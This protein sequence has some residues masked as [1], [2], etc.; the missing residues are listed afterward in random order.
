MEEGF[1]LPPSV[2]KSS[3]RFA[4]G[5]L[6]DCCCWCLTGAIDGGCSVLNTDGFVPPSDGKSSLSIPPSCTEKLL[7]NFT[8]CAIVT[9]AAEGGGA[10]SFAAALSLAV[11]LVSADAAVAVIVDSL[12]VDDDV[13]AFGAYAKSSS[14]SESVSSLIPLISTPA[15]TGFSDDVFV[16]CTG[17]LLLDVRSVFRTSSKRCLDLGECLVLAAP[18]AAAAAAPRKS[19]SL[20]MDRKALA[21]VCSR[22]GSTTLTELVVA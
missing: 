6:C 11:A 3:T 14:T 22:L 19:G 2:G 17:L 4:A 8:L 1:D 12:P 20:A 5:L 7:D 9:A 16:V 21:L 10:L 13:T 15:G 18:P